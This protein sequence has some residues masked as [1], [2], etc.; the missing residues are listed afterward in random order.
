VPLTREVIEVALDL[1]AQFAGPPP[2]VEP[3]RSPGGYA[4][5]VIRTTHTGGPM[6]FDR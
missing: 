3:G 6:T 5:R 4:H 2:G 1:V